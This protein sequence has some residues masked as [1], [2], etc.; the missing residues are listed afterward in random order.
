MTAITQRIGNYLGGVSRQTDDQ[1]LNGQV[2]ECLNSLP[3][4]TFGLTK[5]PGLKHIKNLATSDIHDDAK[6]FY[7][8]RD[9]TQQ[10]IGCITPKPDSG[11]GELKVWNVD[12]T[13]CSVSY[14]GA[15]Q[16]YLDGNRSNYDLL[17][18]QDTTIVTNN[19]DNT[20]AQAAPTFVGS[21]QAVLILTSTLGN[22]NEIFKVKITPAGGS[23]SETANITVTSTSTYDTVIADIKTKIDA[24]SISNLTVTTFSKTITI[25]KTAAFAIEITS[26]GGGL[27]VFQDEVDDITDLP[28]QANHN[29]ILKILNTNAAETT[30][31]AKFVAYN[32]S[33]GPGSWQE[34]KDPAVSVGLDDATMP[35][36]I[37]NTALNTFVFKEIPFTE[38]LVGDL[39][40]NQNPSFV[41]E[42]IQKAF[43][44]D[45]RLGFLSKDNVIM[46]QFGDFYNFFYQS[47]KIIVAQDPV[48]ISASSDRPATLRTVIPT[49]QGLVLFSDNQQFLMTSGQSSNF[50]PTTSSIS[51]ISNYETDSTVE[52]VDMGNFINFVSA[53]PS[54]SR[55]FGMVTRGQQE[56]PEVF[57]LS[58]TVKEWIPTGL[59]TIVAS[60]QNQFLA[61]SSQSSEY[62]YFFR[63]YIKGSTN[64]ED[65]GQA[66]F[67]WKLPGTVQ[68]AVTDSDDMY[69][70]TK[71]AGQFTLL[72]A[73]LSQSPE[74]AIIVNNKGQKINPCVDLYATASSV[75]YDS[76][77][78]ITITNGGS[79]YSSAPT[80]TLAGI[81]G[82][83]AGTPGSGATAT[84]TTLA[85]KVHSITITN[86]GSGY[87]NG[88][89]V[90]FSGG[91]G[92][93]AA[94][95][96]KVYR[97]ST[98]KLPY[99]DATD[100]TPVIVIKGST[101]AGSFVDSGFS[102]TP[103]R[104]YDSDKAFFRVPSKDLTSVASDVIVGYKYDYDVI[105]PKTYYR[106]A[107]GITDYTASL[108]VSRMKFAVGLS[109]ICSFKV[110][111]TGR[112]VG[113]K[114]YVRDSTTLTFSWTTSDLSYVDRNQVKLKINNVESTA[115]TFA[116]DTS[117][118]IT[119]TFSHNFTTSNTTTHTFTWPF[120][121]T[122]VSKIRVLK[123]GVLQ[124]KDV[125]YRIVGKNVIFIDTNGVPAPLPNSTAV[126][127]Y[128]AD[129]ILIYLDEWYNL[130]PTQQSDLY[131]GNDV[132]ITEQ[133]VFTLPI[134]QRTDN[135]QVRLFNDSPYPVS[136]NSMMWE[137]HYSPRFYRRT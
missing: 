53:T 21:K 24:L 115:F 52:P 8:N 91:G 37:V 71:Q 75:T 114:S 109:G 67:N 99:N 85:G 23:A 74:Q 17:T 117:I 29:Q 4:A 88:M 12:G 122:D 69:V 3:D 38:R 137:G 113:Q 116:S 25:T 48:D 9:A 83:A 93:N 126:R 18:V 46:S 45:N 42:K 31:F 58:K 82:S 96:A 56:N 101:A 39:V 34:T 133:S 81:A 87:T 19:K 57:E 28:D 36:Q 124:T 132:P 78:T 50:T 73:N 61:L 105:L 136:L 97:G 27:K 98:C 103:S 15:A 90:S 84:A 2:R 43:F 131:L 13:V 22:T 89:S 54:Y 112:L 35:H 95:T 120:N 102:V 44:A 32:G 86:V 55:V 125:D 119:D 65:T 33:S 70:V 5:R 6:W 60:P 62:I 11:Y 26:G 68:F 30:F 134:H 14:T 111:S 77:D 118:N 10:Y 128:S 40:T 94:A 108:V 107:E 76:L 16:A 64:T 63:L 130:T 110:K 49:R 47:A 59:D 66:W 121:K 41:G 1:K 129:D 79:G 80:V 100:R 72:K 92:S 104:G 20:A 106:L 7:I 51:T 127:I 135:F 123:A